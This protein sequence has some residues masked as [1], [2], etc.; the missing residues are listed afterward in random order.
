MEKESIVDEAVA[1][2]SA[3]L[4]NKLE[5]LF[6]EGLRLKGFEFKNQKE[7]IDFVELNCRCEDRTD[8]NQRTYFVND[9]PFFFH[10]Y[11]QIMDMEVNGTEIGVNISAKLGKYSFL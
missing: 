3:Q 9:I 8:I 2:L 4:A 5:E 11:T 1:K 7:L 6:I 10:D